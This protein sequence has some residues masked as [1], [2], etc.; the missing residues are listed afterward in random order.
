M[1]HK[2]LKMNDLKLRKN[3]TFQFFAKSLT[4]AT[5]VIN[6]CAR[7][8]QIVNAMRM[9]TVIRRAIIFGMLTA[10]IVFGFSYHNKRKSLARNLERVA[11]ALNID[12]VSESLQVEAAYVDNGQE[13]HIVIACRDVTD[14]LDYLLAGRDW[15]ITEASPHWEYVGLEGV[16]VSEYT[17]VREAKWKGD[18]NV[19]AAVL[20]DQDGQSFIVEYHAY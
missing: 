20:F 2:S 11:F 4:S 7:K 19:S 1:I 8:F 12:K 18:G 17:I 14:R 16:K 15:K 10:A 5:E 3:K 13:Y 9:K 6:C